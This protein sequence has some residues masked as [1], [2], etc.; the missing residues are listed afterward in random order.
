MVTFILDAVFGGIVWFVSIIPTITV[1]SGVSSGIEYFFSI[2]G[3]LGFILPL[4]AIGTC[5][6]I[7]LSVYI[8]K[9]TISSTSYVARKIP[10]IS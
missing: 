7:I 2:L 10:T 9:F 4:T 1:P 8:L 3:T 5:L 6:T